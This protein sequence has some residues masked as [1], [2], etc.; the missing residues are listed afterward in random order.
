MIVN[1]EI[2]HASRRGVWWGSTY[3]AVSDSLT[4]TAW[5]MN[6][7]CPQTDGPHWWGEFGSLLFANGC[8]LTYPDPRGFYGSEHGSKNVIRWNK[9]PFED[10]WTDV[11]FKHPIADVRSIGQYLV[12]VMA[13]TSSLPDSL[14]FMYTADLAKGTESHVVIDELNS[15]MANSDNFVAIGNEGRTLAI[16]C[17]IGG[18]YRVYY[19]QLVDPVLPTLTLGSGTTTWIK[20]RP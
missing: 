2:E 4:N 5:K 8:F 18:Q 7:I 16:F 10:K 1:L 3:A 17:Q 13:R 11:R 9:N 15:C 6:V 19:R 12:G 20:A 14:H